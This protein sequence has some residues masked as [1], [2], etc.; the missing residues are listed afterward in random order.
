[1]GTSSFGG[2]ASNNAF[3]DKNVRSGGI[4]FPTGR[5]AANGKGPILIT[6]LRGYASGRGAARSMHMILGPVRT[7]TFSIGAAGSANS[8]GF[9]GVSNGLIANGGSG[10]FTMVFSG[11]SYF[12]HGGGGGTVDSYGTHLSGN[13]G[14]DFNYN[15]VPSAPLSPHVTASGTSATVTWSNPSSNGGAAVTGY[16]IQYATN[17]GFT[18]NVKTV[19]I[20]AV[21]AG[22][23]TGLTA[24]T[25]YWFRVF[26]KNQVTQA[27]GT[28]SVPS[29]S[30]NTSVGDWAASGSHS[31]KAL[32][33]NTGTAP[34]Y[35]SL[36]MYNRS[37]VAGLDTTLKYSASVVVDFAPSGV[38]HK[39]PL[40]IT[41][42][43][44]WYDVSSNIIKTVTGST[45]NIPKGTATFK[46]SNLTIPGG[47]DT[48]CIYVTVPALNASGL[49]NLMV[50]DIVYVDAAMFNNGDP[51]AYFDGNSGGTTAWTGTTNNSTSTKTIPPTAVFYDAYRDNNILYTINTGEV[52]NTAV[53]T[54]NFATQ[55]FAPT[56]TDAAVPGL[57]TYAITDANGDRVTASAWNASGAKVIP[58]IDSEIPGLINLSFIGPKY[59]IPGFLA[60]FQ[61]SQT[62]QANTLATLTIL[63]AGVITKPTTVN[64][65]TGANPATTPADITSTF[66]SPFIT[67]IG[68][69]YDAGVWA[70]VDAAG[71]VL[72]ID[73]SVATK[74][75]EGFGLTAGS[76]VSYQ[77][78]HWRISTVKIGYN[79]SQ[80][81]ADW[82]TTMQDMD[83]A[84]SG[85]LMGAKDIVWSGY[86][87][88]DQLI[89]PLRTA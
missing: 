41:S 49:P 85:Q 87:F 4:G 50:N 55:L 11:M 14:G 76:I 65:L 15:E 30:V 5:I 66:D 38:T 23:V 59:P 33:T 13:L 58:T 44:V 28:Y 10:T 29:T 43:L 39:K 7:G 6:A 60:P 67:D 86:E 68:T 75:L 2:T 36:Q 35:I 52:S 78:A 77:N 57:G 53:Q 56:C 1:M 37:S 83:T 16:M 22:T 74:T 31:Y 42:R 18:A 19:Q 9:R 24:G 21:N 70:A 46:W 63:G 54:T 12:A 48:V 69:L 26:A 27:A 89:E 34:N 61:F 80:V 71:P 64:L 84:W 17:S 40:T 3:T 88:A 82:Y 73:F 47:A 8:T 79:T 62:S 45:F 20:P 32:V 72:S 25:T 81:T 51:T